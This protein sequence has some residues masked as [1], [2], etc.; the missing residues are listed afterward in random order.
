M[1]G[2]KLG[3]F[4]ISLGLLGLSFGS[5]NFLAICICA[6]GSIFAMAGYFVKDV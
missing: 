4:G 1:K 2:I 6:A 5:N 3:L